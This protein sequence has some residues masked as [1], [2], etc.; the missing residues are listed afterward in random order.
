GFD[1]FLPADAPALAL[2]RSWLDAPQHHLLLRGPAGSG[3]SHLCLAAVETQQ[4]AGGGAAY[5]PL[6]ALGTAAAS[7]VE[8]Q[9]AVAL[10]VVDDLDESRVDDGLQRALFG[11]HNRVG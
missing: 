11:L 1:D 4:Q 3:K 6:A 9:P 2:L 7:M 8:A 5:L 10:V